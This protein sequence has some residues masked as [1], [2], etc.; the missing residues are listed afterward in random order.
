LSSD[1]YIVVLKQKCNNI[2]HAPF[3]ADIVHVPDVQL[4]CGRT[5]QCSDHLV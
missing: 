4:S 1:H 5:L 2:R 3:T